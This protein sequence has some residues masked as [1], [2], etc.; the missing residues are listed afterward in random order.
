MRVI[1]R[2][3]RLVP[4]RL[5]SLLPHFPVRNTAL[6]LWERFNQDS[7]ALTASSLTFTTMLGLVPLLAVM[8]AIFT[9]FPLFRELEVALERWLVHNLVPRS[10]SQ[11]VLDYLTQFAAQANELGLL[12]LVGLVFTSLSMIY[13]IDQTLNAIW[14]VRESR[15][16]AQRLLLYWAVLSLG[17]VAAGGSVAITSFLMAEARGWVNDVAPGMGVLL[18]TAQV[19]LLMLGL[20]LLYKLVPNTPVRWSHALA[21]G[22]FA[23]ACLSLGRWG[24]GLYLSNIPTYS[25]IYGAFATLPILLVWVYVAWLI[26]LLGAVVAAYAP[27]LMA[28]V[29][30]RPSTGGWQFQVA[31]EVLQLLARAQRGPAR[32]RS[33][34]WLARRLR[35]DAQQ[36][37]P[38]FDALQAMGWVGLLEEPE[39]DDPRLVLL[40][41]PAQTPLAPLVTQ[42]L[43]GDNPST[44]ALWQRLNL[45]APRLADALGDGT[46]AAGFLPPSAN[47]RQAAHRA[48]R[49]GWR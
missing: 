8:L 2:L 32:G 1:K 23:A 14:R 16:W 20:S 26:I 37:Q 36:V 9:A 43:F 27:A 42:L 45:D 47:L 11:S 10:I 48:R 35:L 24:I 44:H 18:N 29:A 41:D 12:G 7:L 3:S 38:A 33:M 4:E 17:P 6:T 25:L 49:G 40:I 34:P 46:V 39:R 28:G 30:R 21:G 13:T 31:L 22:L 5:Q 19:A 15:P